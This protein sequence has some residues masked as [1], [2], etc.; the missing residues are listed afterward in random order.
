MPSHA[1]SGQ[2]TPPPDAP[3]PAS[4]KT[5]AGRTP[6]RPGRPFFKPFL[7]LT[8]FREY[9]RWTQRQAAQWLG[10]SQPAWCNYEHGT[11][12]IPDELKD[13][14]LRYGVAL[15]AVLKPK[16]SGYYNPKRHR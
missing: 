7:S 4:P 2:T 15:S 1:V 13:K 5:R 6:R 9:R 11:R 3:P 16:P 12:Q 10:C 14:L 8:E